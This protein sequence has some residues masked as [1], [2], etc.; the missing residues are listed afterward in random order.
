[1]YGQNSYPSFCPHTLPHIQKGHT[2]QVLST[3]GYA[4]YTACGVT[5]DLLHSRLGNAIRQMG[6]VLCIH[7]SWAVIFKV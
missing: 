1:M 5:A 2:C 7:P 3:I 6:K 4:E